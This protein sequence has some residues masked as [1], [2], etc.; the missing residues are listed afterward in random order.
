M[1]D[2]LGIAAV[3]ALLGAG[4]L[5][6]KSFNKTMRAE[7][8]MAQEKRLVALR[9]N[10]ITGDCSDFFRRTEQEYENDISNAFP[11]RNQITNYIRYQMPDE[12]RKLNAI[13]PHYSYDA[14]SDMADYRTLLES[15]DAIY[16]SAMGETSDYVYANRIM[17]AAAKSLFDALEV[18][19]NLDPKMTYTQ[20][21][22]TPDGE[23]AAKNVQKAIETCNLRLGEEYTIKLASDTLPRGQYL[24]QQNLD[25][26]AAN[27]SYNKRVNYP[28]NTYQL[29]MAFDEGRKFVFP[30][31]KLSKVNREMT[32]SQSVYKPLFTK[33]DVEMIKEYILKN[34][35]YRNYAIV[36]SYNE[37]FKRNPEIKSVGFDKFRQKYYS[38]EFTESSIPVGLITVDGYGGGI[39]WD[40]EIFSS[41]NE[42]ESRD[43]TKSSIDETINIYKKAQKAMK[44]KE[45]KRGNLNKK[46]ETEQREYLTK[47]LTEGFAQYDNVESRVKDRLVESYIVLV[48]NEVSQYPTHDFGIDEYPSVMGDEPK[49]SKGRISYHKVRPTVE[50]H[51]IDVSLLAPASLKADAKAQFEAAM[52]REIQLT[53]EELESAQKKLDRVEKKKTDGLNRL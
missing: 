3:A 24:V 39:V 29:Q 53:Q 45:K 40:K 41:F 50:R 31:S 6:T 32:H 21:V 36:V 7:T 1:N 52:N 42:A 17:S 38:V 37:F 10:R 25:V 49:I 33:D 35:H 2:K 11:N 34:S 28:L 15:L 23:R 51:N 5:T 12:R 16:V 43:L 30:K 4:L 20:F 27:F 8:F 22:Q 13:H 48:M 26:L 18:A 46:I 44:R 9:E 47:K 14:L 19:S